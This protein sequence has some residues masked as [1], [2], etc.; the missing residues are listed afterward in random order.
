MGTKQRSFLFFSYL[1]S[2]ALATK[3][4]SNNLLG[5]FQAQKIGCCELKKQLNNVKGLDQAGD[6]R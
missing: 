5:G 1:C 4:T 6:A 2:V 3:A